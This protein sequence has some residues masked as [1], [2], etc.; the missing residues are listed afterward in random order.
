MQ[1][2]SRVKKSLLNARVNLIFYFITLALS[3]F[4]RKI[5]LDCLGADFVGLTGTLTNIL[6]FLSLAEMGVGIAV[7]Y[8]LYKP[9]QVGDKT[10]IEELVSVFGY[11]YRRIGSFVALGGVAI[12]AFI[13]WIFKDSGFDVGLIY[14]AFYAILSSSLLSYFINYRQIILNADQRGY[15]VTGY[16]QGVGYVKTLLQMAVAYYW[17]NFYLWIALEVIFGLTAC[18]I[19][20]WKIRRV[21]PW[22]QAS[23]KKGKQ[24][25]PQHKSIVTYTKQIFIHKI[26]DFLL[27]QSDQI[28]V[29]AFVSLK[30]V[31]YYGNYTLITTKLSHLFSTF[32]SGFW[33]GV[34]NLIAEGDKEKTVGVFW[35]IHSLYYLCGGFIVFSVYHLITPFIT[36]WLGA[37][38]LLDKSVL[39]L[40]M[41]NVFILQTRGAVD[42]FNGGHGQFADTWSAWAE[43]ITNIGITLI[44][45]PFWGIIGILAGKIVSLFFF[46]VLWKPYY[47]FHSAFQLPIW[48]YWKETL[49]YWLI[50]GICFYAGHKLYIHIPIE[51]SNSFLNWALKALVSVIPFI[52]LYFVAMYG[53]SKGVQRISQRVIVR[54]CPSMKY[55]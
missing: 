20:N 34:G 10:Q 9:L 12:S 44:C 7:S 50:F 41:I 27:F 52:I 49:K 47:L 51:A 1:Q 15:V 31:A 36:L 5:F 23:V 6:G 4:S 54:I 24:A 19:L 39:A 30:M 53:C 28:L 22:L 26:K 17:G 25:F 46:V 29:F 8:H 55:K 18:V 11:L 14:F 42:M 35:E 40:L 33:A 21:Y 48:I 2:E 16:L 3:F 38:Y 45:A 32:L 43:G 37:E 13:P